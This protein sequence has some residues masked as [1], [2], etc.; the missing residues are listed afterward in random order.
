MY[1]DSRKIHI[2]EAVLKTEDAR[3]D[4]LVGREK[5]LSKMDEV[6]EQSVKPEN[7]R[8]AKDFLG[9]WNKKDAGAI[10]K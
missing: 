1:A 5:I 10:E 7:K 4:N 3:P 6:I 2:I 9:R 8:S